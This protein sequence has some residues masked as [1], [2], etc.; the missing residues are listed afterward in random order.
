MHNIFD[1]EEN[2]LNA[3]FNNQFAGLDINDYPPNMDFSLA[4]K[5]SKMVEEEDKT[6]EELEKEEE[7]EDEEQ[8]RDERMELEEYDN[9]LPEFEEPQL[10]FADDLKNIKDALKGAKRGQINFEALSDKVNLDPSHLFY[11]LLVMAQQDQI[12][13][14]QRDIFVNSSI[15]ITMH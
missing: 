5:I 13:I 12:D 10:T 9:R 11:D 8:P 6:R 14:T 1:T 15:M 7:R 2:Y 3:G 4:E